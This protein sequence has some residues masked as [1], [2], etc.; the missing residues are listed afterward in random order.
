MR[1][2][3]RFLNKGVAIVLLALASCE[4]TPQEGGP[5]NQPLGGARTLAPPP[6][7]M[8]DVGIL[9]DQSTYQPARYGPAEPGTVQT[10]GGEGGEQEQ[11]AIRARI[12]EILQAA[13]SRNVEALF[14]AFVQEQIA[15][16]LPLKSAV[17]E[18]VEK[19]EALQRQLTQLGGPAAQPDEGQ[20]AS[21]EAL[22]GKLLDAFVAGLAVDVLSADQAAVRVDAARFQES[23]TP[24]VPEIQRALEQMAAAGGGPGGAGVLP[25]LS[26]EQQIADA[27]QQ[28]AGFTLS[29]SRVEEVW[30]I[31]LPFALT[32]AHAEIGRDGLGLL[33]EYLDKVMERLQ[34]LESADQAAI[35]NLLMEVSFEVLPR[36]MALMQKVQALQAGAGPAEE[37]D[38]SAPQSPGED[39]ESPE[40]QE[41]PAGPPRGGRSPRSP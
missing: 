31:A 26:L 30:R 27:A 1:I 25:P 40:D 6:A 9:A 23:L 8:I 39:E 2:G 38:S 15:P 36:L 28:L 11:E 3:C 18:T 22:V 33:N 24:L 29:V 35:S 37:A 13:I 7:P 41:A 4:R 20:A 5:F 10:A 14:D 32:E 16:V 21:Q 34:S 12:R 17:I 19:L